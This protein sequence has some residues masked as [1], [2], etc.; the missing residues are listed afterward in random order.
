MAEILLGVL[1][2]HLAFMTTNRA[3]NDNFRTGTGGRIGVGRIS[4][5]WVHALT[6]RV[7]PLDCNTNRAQQ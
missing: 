2:Q 6:L 1:T 7:S 3:F 4:V 5:G